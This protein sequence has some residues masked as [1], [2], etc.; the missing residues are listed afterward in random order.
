MTAGASWFNIDHL[1]SQDSL[2]SFDLGSVVLSIGHP[3]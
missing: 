3:S 1:C 2:S